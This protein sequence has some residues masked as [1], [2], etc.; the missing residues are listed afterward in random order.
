MRALTHASALPPACLQA[1]SFE[2]EAD[3]SSWGEYVRGGIV[4]QV[5]E[6]KSLSFKKLEQVGAETGVGVGVG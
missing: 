4:V 5:K 2:I 6:S 3:T 1:H